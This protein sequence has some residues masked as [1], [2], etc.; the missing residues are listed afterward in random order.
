LVEWF[1]LTTAVIG[2]VAVAAVFANDRVRAETAVHKVG[3]VSW[4]AQT[5]IGQDVTIVGYVLAVEKD[6]VFVSDERTGKISAHDLPVTGIGIDQL[7][8]AVKYVLQG[9]LLDR[10]LKARNGSPYH[11][12]LTAPPQETK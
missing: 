3:E 12:E 2:V 11:L 1:R 7:R 6:Y 4:H 5:L 9:K 8:P 10:G